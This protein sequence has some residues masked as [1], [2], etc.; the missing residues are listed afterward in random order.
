[1]LPTALL[2]QGAPL[3]TFP[4]LSRAW[5]TA[6]LLACLWPAVHAAGPG[7]TATP[8][9]LP[10][11]EPSFTHVSVAGDTLIGLGRRYLVQPAQWP[12]LQHLN[13][14]ANPR[15]IPVGT[16]LRIPLRLMVTEAVPAQLLATSGDVRDAEGRVLSAGQPVPQGGRLTTG[17]GQ[18]TVQLVDGTLLQLRPSSTLQ[19]DTSQRLPQAGVTRSGVQLQQGQLEVKARKAEGGAPGFRVGTPQGVLGVRGTEFRVVVDPQAGQTRGEVLEGLVAVAGTGP[20]RSS[21]SAEAAGG[22]L[23]SAGQG[24]VVERDGAVAPPSALPAAPDL[25]GQPQRH[26]KPLLRFTLQAAAGAVAYRG[27]VAADEGFGQ[28]LSD[29]RSP[30][31]GGQAELRFADLPDGSYLLRVRAEDDRGL[32][33]LDG[34]LRFTLKARPEPPL[35]RS[36]AP[37]AVLSGGQ[38][39]FA[40]TTSSQAL[41]YR[42][43]I[44]RS[45]DF[46]QPLRDERGLTAA[47]RQ[48]DGLAPGVYWW[49]LASERSSSDQGP[50]GAP[51]RFEL[52]ALPA[53]LLPPRVN[54]DGVDLTWE[55]RPGQTFELQFARDA[56]FTTLVLVRETS[57]PTLKA[58]LPGPG[59]YF[60]RLRARDPDG[61]LGPF[62]AAQQFELPSCLRDGQ[63]RCVGAGDASWALTVP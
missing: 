20:S 60:V 45:E 43:Q 47:A 15:R 52:R 6:L 13:R 25:A 46:G 2:L 4:T 57:E 41:S 16:P 37:P 62:T 35:P 49:R 59:R 17:D 12:E 32:Q 44:A 38:V 48:V 11:V 61:F 21:G 1:M 29:S 36:P 19:V 50:F 55:G 28:V 3:R 56:G 40:W 27:Q 63:R 8:P 7:Q 58:T 24:V 34:L 31:Q 5:S 9:L 23:V 30:V 22:Q 42:L 51:Q 10:S 26:E 54:E 18:A 14:V 53:P 39:N 33:G